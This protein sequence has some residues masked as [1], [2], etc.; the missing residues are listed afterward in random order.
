MSS[1]PLTDKE[2][3][4]ICSNTWDSSWLDLVP[5]VGSSL[6]SYGWAKKNTAGQKIRQKQFD[7]LSSRVK[8]Q[9]AQWQRDISNV[10]RDQAQE[11]DDLVTLINGNGTDESYVD[12]LIDKKLAPES[13]RITYLT[14]N[15]INLAVIVFA[16]IFFGK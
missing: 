7:D 14:V 12:M 3:R 15:G 13:H 8:T 11:I 1:C 16:L 5:F 9:T 2:K 4:N 10:V 6:K